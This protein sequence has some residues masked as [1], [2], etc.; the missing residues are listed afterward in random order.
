MLKF[1]LVYSNIYE[2]INCVGKE[3]TQEIIK[4]FSVLSSKV[5]WSSDRN[6]SIVV[7]RDQRK[8]SNHLQHWHHCKSVLHWNI[9]MYTLYQH[10]NKS[11]CKLISCIGWSLYTLAFP[12]GGVHLESCG[13]LTE[14]FP[15]ELSRPRETKLFTVPVAHLP[16]SGHL[17]KLHHTA[18]WLYIC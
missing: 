4:N 12:S 15:A 14:V 13:A 11:I 9:H 3:E 10:T 2:D 5:T 7:A 6:H 18:M 1:I 16:D 8:S 17:P